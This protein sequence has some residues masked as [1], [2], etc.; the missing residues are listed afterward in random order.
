MADG[1]AG[2]ELIC[3]PEA[4]DVCV[5]MQGSYSEPPAV[6]IHEHC[7][8]VVTGPDEDCS[9]EVRNVHEDEDQFDWTLPAVEY[10]NCGGEATSTVFGPNEGINV[11]DADPEM[12]EYLLEGGDVEP[13]IALIPADSEGSVDVTV[14]MKSKIAV[15]EL[16]QICA[17]SDP[18]A[19]TNV[20]ETYL[21]DVGAYSQVAD[22]VLDV[23]VH[24]NPCY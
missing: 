11:R 21:R 8:C 24:A 4:C 9:A 16:W 6:P 14:V 20:V 2:Y 15:G 5:G 12:Q 13:M 19:G 1:D 18:I 10:S 3:G 17:H 7:Q 22:H 23:E